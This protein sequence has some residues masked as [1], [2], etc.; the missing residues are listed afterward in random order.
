VWCSVPVV[1]VSVWLFGGGG[2]FL[3]PAPHA[4]RAPSASLRDG[5]ATL[6]PRASAALGQALTGRLAPAFLC[7][8]PPPNRLTGGCRPCC[9]FAGCP[10]L[11]EPFA[12]GSRLC[13]ASAS[14]GGPHC[15]APSLG[16]LAWVSVAGGSRLR[17]AFAG[18]LA[19]V[20]LRSWPSPGVALRRAL[21]LCA[22]A[23]VFLRWP[24]VAGLVCVGPSLKV[25][26]GGCV[27]G[28]LL[29]V[30]LLVV[31]WVFC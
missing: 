1:L 17:R 29:F 11:R 24:S 20:R 6:D 18:A 30:S 28:L 4:S 14:A 21:A 3:R 22:F 15:V 27:V 8:P 25:F 23:V 12:G 16:T 9:A 31:L 10:R 19:C 2:G 13:R 7:P 5:F 26:A